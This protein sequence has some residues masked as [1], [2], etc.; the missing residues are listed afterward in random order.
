MQKLPSLL[1]APLQEI[2]IPDSVVS[3][4]LF[5]YIYVSKNFQTLKTF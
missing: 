3:F 1:S 2:N 4:L 5:I